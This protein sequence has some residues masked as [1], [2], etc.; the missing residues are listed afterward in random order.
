MS[1][2]LSRS[3]ETGDRKLQRMRSKEEKQRRN[4]GKTSASASYQ[5]QHLL[6]PRKGSAVSPK[7]NYSGSRGKAWHT[8]RR[9]K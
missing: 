5:K 7:T 2:G 9:E 6:F 3:K 4:K 1:A 8:I